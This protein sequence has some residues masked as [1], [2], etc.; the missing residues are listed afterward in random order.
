MKQASL[1]AIAWLWFHLF[2]YGQQPGTLDFSFGEEGI[3]QTGFG[4]GLQAMAMETLADGKILVVG[5]YMENDVRGLIMLRYLPDGTPDILFGN[6]G[7][8][9]VT[10][11][12]LGYLHFAKIQPD[13][14]SVFLGSQAQ[15]SNF[16]L[17]RYSPQGEWDTAFG[18]AGILEPHP[19]N[20]INYYTDLA[21]LP[22]GKMV[23]GAYGFAFSFSNADIFLAQYNPD[24]S[25]D[26]SFGYLGQA[27][28]P[29]PNEQHLRRIAL[30]SDGKI[31]ATG[32][33]HISGS[34]NS[35]GRTFVARFNAD[36]RI[37]EDFGYGGSIT[38][39]TGSPTTIR[40]KPDGKIVVGGGRDSDLSQGFLA[41][42]Q[43]HPN[44]LPDHSFG[45]FGRVS[46][47][48]PAEIGIIPKLECLPNGDLFL[49]SIMQHRAALWRFHPD[50]SPDTAFGSNG[51]MHM[52][53][54]GRQITPELILLTQQD[55][56]LLTATINKDDIML[57]RSLADGNMD[58][59]FA[60]QGLHI[61]DLGSNHFTAGPVA[62]TADGRIVAATVMGN[63]FVLMRYLP[64]GSLD[65][66]YGTGGMA[67]ANLPPNVYF[68]NVVL[69]MDAQGVAIV[70]L[71]YYDQWQW[72]RPN[73]IYLVRFHADGALDHSFGSNGSLSPEFGEGESYCA[74]IHVSEDG[75]ILLAGAFTNTN[76]TSF[77]CMA[78]YHPNGQADNDFGTAG[79]AVSQTA[80][81]AYC[82]DM[83]VQPDG[84]L[85]LAGGSTT[86]PVISRFVMARYFPNGFIDASFGQ[87]GRVETAFPSQSAQILH[88]ALQPDGKILVV[89]NGTQQIFMRYLPDGTIDT[90]FGTAGIVSTD[91]VP[92]GVQQIHVQSNGN[93]WLTG[94]K[95]LGSFTYEPAFMELDAYGVPD[96]TLGVDGIVMLQAF[97]NA[98]TS[99]SLLQAD[100]KLVLA[101][102][103]GSRLF[104]ARFHSNLSVHTAQ[105]VRSHFDLKVFPNPVEENLAIEYTLPRSGRL[106]IRLLDA[107]GRAVLTLLANAQR[108]EGRYI[109]QYRLPAG[110]PAGLYFVRVEAG[111][112]SAQAKVIKR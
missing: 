21:F 101:G 56:L 3:V 46:F 74:A 112:S 48:A 64:N 1:L 75:K 80:A 79:I 40:I 39:G 12:P 53:W 47:N 99:G 58:E 55:K 15:T 10:L 54:E 61:T 30:Q 49:Y 107:S 9:L 82:Y 97:P 20:Y 72:P 92:I 104:L 78:R 93:I 81:N 4:A 57:G 63:R 28:L 69:G 85:V 51:L 76:N 41:M 26:S 19:F 2:T 22:N 25:R 7:K 38:L 67:F 29:L 66:T 88:L 86:S 110:L 16:A 102:K 37:D 36:G 23:I 14:G 33:S 52:D 71:N 5:S 96:F 94:S 11:P 83:V 59:S 35:P 111:G 8:R 109:E 45:V 68:S 91:Q 17:T 87:F 60:G 62:Q 31:I 77:F 6:G 100:N 103:A 98:F 42:E 73:R 18:N 70:A 13:D 95:S 43:L 32:S 24:G 44:G 89:G 34:S 108:E 105:P 50:G 106:H 65:D 84:K 90:G 27:H